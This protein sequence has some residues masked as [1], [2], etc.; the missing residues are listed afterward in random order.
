LFAVTANVRHKSAAAKGLTQAF[1]YHLQLAKILHIHQLAEMC[2][3]DELM[4]GYL[5]GRTQLS[6]LTIAGLED[7]GYEVNYANSDYLGADDINPKCMCKT[8]R[9]LIDELPQQQQS[10]QQQPRKLRHG[11]VTLLHHTP[12]EHRRKLSDAGHLE[13]LTTGREILAKLHQQFGGGAA[14]SNS[15]DLEFAADRVVSVL[16]I[17]GHEIYGVLVEAGDRMP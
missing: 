4:T 14:V 15:T 13:A 6:R 10:P 16:M 12:S 11:D 1:S 3:G 9:E 8:R 5:G 7:L 2:L 17:E